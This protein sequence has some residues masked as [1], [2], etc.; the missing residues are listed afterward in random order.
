[1]SMLEALLEDGV[2]MAIINL[3]VLV[4]FA[5]AVVGVPF[6]LFGPKDKGPDDR[7]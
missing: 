1:M 5:L 4:V 3:A 6:L 7:T 2:V